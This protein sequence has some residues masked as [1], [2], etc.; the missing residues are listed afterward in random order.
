MILR[1]NRVFQQINPPTLRKRQGSFRILPLPLYFR[2]P[3]PG[4]CGR[5]GKEKS[6]DR[7]ACGFF[8][9]SVE[10]CPGYYLRR[11]NALMRER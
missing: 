3:V 1:G 10:I 4:R 7:L 8:S 9:V 2:I 6:A 11:P 5:G